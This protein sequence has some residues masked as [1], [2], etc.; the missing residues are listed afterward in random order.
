MLTSEC[1]GLQYGSSRRAAGPFLIEPQAQTLHA[2]EVMDSFFTICESPRLV[3][4]YHD[5]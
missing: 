4:I 2:E 1:V 5:L 3:I